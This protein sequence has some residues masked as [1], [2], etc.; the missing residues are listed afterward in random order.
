[1]GNTYPYTIDN[2]TADILAAQALG[3]DGFA[4]NLGL[5]SWQPA[6]IADAYSAAAGVAARNHS[7]KPFYLFLSFDMTCISDV[8]AIVNY[9]RTYHGHP[10][11]FVYQGKD[12]VST[13]SGEGV[14]LGQSNLND[15]WQ[16][17]VKNV[18]AAEGI[19]IYF[20]PAWSALDP[21]TVFTN[22]P[23][24]DGL[25]CWTAWYEIQ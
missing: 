19:L 14:F 18:L 1:M 23:V 5:D 25:F 12:F 11:Q 15:A 9:I 16:I 6:R 3:I 17:G 4:L 7:A 8:S 13:F 20:V 24:L 21:Q 2:W 10:C 22:Y